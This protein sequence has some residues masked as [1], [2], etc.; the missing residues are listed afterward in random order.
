[1][2]ILMAS[3]FSGYY[4]ALFLILW[5]LI[6]RGISIEVG[7]HTKDCLW[8]QLWNF[9]FSVSNLLL[10]VLFGAAA[11]NVGRGVPIDVNG[12]FS[13]AFFTNFRVRGNVGLLDWYTTSIAIFTVVLL[14]AHGATYL[15]LKTQGPVHDRSAYYARWLWL[16]VLPLLIAISFESWIVRPA[17]LHNAFRNP[18]CWLGV[19]VILGS[20]ITLAFGLWA[21]LE[22]CAFAASNLLIM[23]LLAVGGSAIFPVMLY[24]TLGPQYSLNAYAVS[25]NHTALVF[26][27]FWWPVGFILAATYF[28]FI[29][30]H[31]AGKVDTN[32]DSQGFY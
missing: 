30:R 14:A 32:R 29:S 11:G 20:A 26:A 16:A 13:M 10:A 28:V 8:Q 5:C 7:G 17:V 12:D 23:G 19:F 18:L 6:L 15:E 25:T 9:V 31:Y 1:M 22:T 3:A 4:L 27:S 2:S 24:S 21:R